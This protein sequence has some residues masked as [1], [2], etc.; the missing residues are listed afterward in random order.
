MKVL[1]LLVVAIYAQ[2]QSGFPTSLYTPLLAKDNIQTS[3]TSPMAIGDNV[4]IVQSGTGWAPQM[5]AYICDST[6]GTPAK[7]T[8]YEVM[9]VTAVSG[10]VL[11][12]TR[13]YGGSTAKSHATGKLIQNAYTSVYTNSAQNEL[14]NMQKFTGGP[15][16]VDLRAY[17]AVCDDVTN[18]QP[19]VAAAIAAGYKQIFLP[20][21]CLWIPTSNRI[22]DGVHVMGEDW[23]YSRIETTSVTTVQLTAGYGAILENIVTKN[24]W[25]LTQTYPMN[26]DH[27]CQTHYWDNFRGPGIDLTVA[28]WDQEHITLNRG[29]GS[30]D[31]PGIAIGQ[32]GVG[33]GLW[34]GVDGAGAGIRF[35][36]TGPNFTGWLMIADVGLPGGTETGMGYL[37]NVNNNTARGI[38]INRVGTGTGL[39]VA[40]TSASGSDVVIS[41][42]SKTSG[43]MLTF[44]QDT[45]TYTGTPILMNMASSF[46]G[47]FIDLTVNNSS[48]WWVDQGGNATAAGNV[49]AGGGA[50][51]VSRCLTA[52]ALP[53]GALTAN[54]AACGTSTPMGFVG[55]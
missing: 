14:L 27:S 4:A 48:K 23:A 21:H 1:L 31:M 33:D 9:L 15:R 7:C 17:G 46:S 52:G 51:P 30:R 40:S 28:F 6:S 24:Q 37:V 54:T 5:V 45:S 11:T 50:I 25:C 19:A 36:G 41:S 10:N 38:Q 39:I 35:Y 12:V 55:K 29:S 3:L 18:V 16:Y 20:A 26:V 2:A 8:S 13:A 42:S 34:I 43:A 49:T 53:V 32:G 44:F 47:R 22:P